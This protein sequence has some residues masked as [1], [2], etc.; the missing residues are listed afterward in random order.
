MTEYYFMLF[1]LLFC[2]IIGLFM[3][4]LTQTDGRVGRRWNDLKNGRGRNGPKKGYVKPN[5]LLRKLPFKDTDDNPLLYI[6]IVPVV[7]HFIIFLV[8]VAMYILLWIFP[9]TFEPILTSYWCLGV[10]LAIGLVPMIYNG[11]LSI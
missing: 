7:I 2:S 1:S 8:A 4:I 6:K 10:S 5:S 11:I 3:S 9:D